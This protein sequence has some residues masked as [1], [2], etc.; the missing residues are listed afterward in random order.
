MSILDLP[1]PPV[2]TSL[3]ESLEHSMAEYVQLGS[4]GL[5]ISIPIFGCM[6]LGNREWAPWVIEEA[7]VCFRCY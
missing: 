2:P 1:R 7:E 3:K 6:S 4:S 5:R